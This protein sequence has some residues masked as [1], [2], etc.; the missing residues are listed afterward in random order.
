MILNFRNSAPVWTIQ[1]AGGANSVDFDAFIG[2]EF[3][4]QNAVAHEPIEEGG[5]AAYNKQGT[6][7]E[8]AVILACTKPYAEQQPVLEA[9]DKL[10][11]GL[12][13]VS[14]VTPSAEYK[15]L[16]IEAYSYARKEDAGAGMLVIE[17]KLIEIREVEVQKTVAASER[18]AP[19][20]TQG[21]SKNPS[22]TS[23]SN[24]GRTQAKEPRKSVLKSG[25]DKFRGWMGRG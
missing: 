6:P 13:K 20:I 9:L 18:K 11:A 8:I 15:D 24:T 21:Q 23:T 19:P 7:K 2:L 1:G 16:N 14:L 25:M 17:L 3:A 22:N 12:E 10:A 4:N 5:F